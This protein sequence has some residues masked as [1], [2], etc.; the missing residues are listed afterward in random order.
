[1]DETYR[2]AR[3]MD[4]NRFS[5]PL[6]PDHTDLIKIVRDYLLEG[7]DSTRKIKVEL[8]KL[9]VYNVRISCGRV[10][11]PHV[12][13]ALLLRHRGQEWT[14]DSASVLAVAQPSSVAYAAFFSD[15][16]HEVV[17]VT[18]GHRVTLTYN[19]YFDDN[20]RPS[21]KDLVLEPPSAPQDENE[22]MFRSAFEAL[23]KNP[24][25]LPD[26]GTLGFGLRHVY[27]VEHTLEHVYSLL[28]GSD[29]TVYQSVRAL[30]FEP[31]KRK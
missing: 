1:M 10:S 16:E 15:V 30:G 26:G 29:A 21:A 22:R 23:L 31:T 8:Y 5:T 25:F 27:Q 12:G 24:E 13:G 17:P 3:K 19:L 7:T 28:K 11:N 6:V 14:F 2:K 18:S 20:K 9:N 4:T